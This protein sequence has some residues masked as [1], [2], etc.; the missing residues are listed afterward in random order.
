[1][2]QVEQKADLLDLNMD[3]G[4]IEGVPAMTKFVNLLV[5][6]PEVSRVPF[7]IDSSKFHI[8]EVRWLCALQLIYVSSSAAGL[9]STWVRHWCS[10]CRESRHYSEASGQDLL[11]GVRRAAVA[12]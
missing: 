1:M 9:R 10:P 11:Q 3:D 2:E 6:D 4:L 12:S 7:M 5:S 8:V